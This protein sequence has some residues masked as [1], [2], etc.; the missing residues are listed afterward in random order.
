MQ[1]VGA[2]LDPDVYD[3]TVFP[4]IF[5][6]GILLGIEFLN[7]IDGHF[8]GDVSD[9][10]RGVQKTSVGALA[11]FDEPFEQQEVRSRT[12]AVGSRVA[13]SAVPLD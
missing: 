1:T 6:L 13:C 3:R 11:Y 10:E 2:R 8:G 12:P 9:A 7:C 4:A 5:R